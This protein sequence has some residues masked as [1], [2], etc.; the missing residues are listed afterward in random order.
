MMEALAAKALLLDDLTHEVFEAAIAGD[1][2][3]ALELFRRFAKAKKEM[4]LAT[5]RKFSPS[6]FDMM[7]SSQCSGVVSLR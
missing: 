6:L 1:V 4:R 5:I 7:N 3:S 2:D